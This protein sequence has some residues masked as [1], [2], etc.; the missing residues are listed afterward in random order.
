MAGCAGGLRG[1]EIE[2]ERLN[3]TEILGDLICDF[4]LPSTVELR[5]ART[6]GGGHQVRQSLPIGVLNRSEQL[7]L[8]P[9]V[10]DVI[11]FRPATRGKGWGRIAIS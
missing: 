10:A 7:G 2:F 9:P 4:Q 5:T 8:R 1:A 3:I 6:L 11:A